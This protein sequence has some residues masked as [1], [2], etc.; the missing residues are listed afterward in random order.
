MEKARDGFFHR[1][2]RE[3]G[4]EQAV[5]GS[6]AVQLSTRTLE[7]SKG[8]CGL[9]AFAITAI[10][11]DLE[12]DTMNTRFTRATPKKLMV[13]TLAA[14]ALGGSDQVLARGDRYDDHGRDRGHRHGDRYGDRHH[15]DH[16]AGHRHHVYRYPRDYYPR[17]QHHHYYGYPYGVF[18]LGVLTGYLLDGYDY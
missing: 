9:S 3:N 6:G 7:S 8:D 11:N 4:A 16:W 5:S 2:P 10:V 13:V 15:R 18:G 1:F 17:H 12:V 14:L